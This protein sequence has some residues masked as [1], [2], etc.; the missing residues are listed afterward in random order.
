MGVGLCNN[1]ANGGGGYVII[2]LAG[3]V[4]II[5]LLMGWV[6]IIILLAGYM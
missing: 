6:Y 3:W 5:I 2:L 1:F 4:Y